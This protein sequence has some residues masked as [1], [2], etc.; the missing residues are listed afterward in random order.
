MAFT[1][2]INQVDQPRSQESVR[3]AAW[4]GYTGLVASAVS[5]LLLIANPATWGPV[6]GYVLGAVITPG[7]A[8]AHRYSLESRQKNPWFVRARRPGQIVVAALVIGMVAGI[9][10]TWLLATELAKQ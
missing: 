3:V 9:G 6:L 7:L 2:A 5:V 4:P 8:V 1:E 10:H